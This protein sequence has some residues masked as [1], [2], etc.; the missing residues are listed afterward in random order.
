MFFK[1]L[2]WKLFGHPSA[3]A[4]LSSFT[5]TIH[6]LRVVAEH[7]GD[8]HAEKLEQARS[9]TNQARGH[10]DEQDIAHAVAEKLSALIDSHQIRAI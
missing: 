9:L 8:Q 5:N 3:A 2:F 6:E 4:V 7:H 10:S 1:K